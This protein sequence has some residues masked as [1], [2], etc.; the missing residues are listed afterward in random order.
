LRDIPNMARPKRINIPYCLFH[1]FSRT[2]SG[3]RA[4]LDQKDQ[5]RFL[6]YLEKY[7]G[8][9][10]FRIHAWCMMPTHFHILL[11]STEKS[12]ISELMRRLL[13]AYTVYFNRR[14]G[15]HGHLFQG[16]FKSLV[17]DK[18]NYLL[19][20]SW[21]IHRNPDSGKPGINPETYAGSSLGYYINGGEPAF[22]HTSEI[23]SWFKGDRA[24]Y[25]E[26]MRKGLDEETK[27]M[28][29]QQRFIG[30]EAFVERLKRRLN[31]M[32]KRGAR[33]SQAMNKAKKQVREKE[34]MFAKA[35]TGKVGRYF[36][37][38]GLKIVKENH[39]HGDISRGRTVLMALLRN[40]LP[41]QITDIADY[42]NV[43]EK[44]GVYYHLNLIKKDQALQQAIEEI[45]KEIVKEGEFYNF[46]ESDPKRGGVN[47]FTLM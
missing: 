8:L 35:I 14:H 26:F 11:E 37:S 7:A 22:L 34:L 36:H 2:N 4:F 12:A 44:S 43:R 27:P 46:I 39:T 16:R 33:G 25:A 42:M 15:R 19:A 45:S 17:V 18:A 23:L 47:L 29:I 31:L 32:K 21:Y 10:S 1:V 28:I 6:E 41:W 24:Q 38:D 13:T 5:C 3:D 40:F 20:L 9:F 30:N